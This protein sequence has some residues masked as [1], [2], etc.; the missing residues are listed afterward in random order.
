MAGNNTVCPCCGRH[1]SIE[2]LHCP[3]GMAHFGIEADGGGSRNHH[4]HRK[5]DI[6]T[7][8]SAI[9]LIRQCGHFLHHSMPGGGSDDE[10]L[11]FLTDDE[12][13]QLSEILKKCL[14]NWQ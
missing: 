14:K 9:T 1:C 11:S 8:A 7:E 4:G 12:K 10:L 2:D 3:R 13:T 6:D 5:F